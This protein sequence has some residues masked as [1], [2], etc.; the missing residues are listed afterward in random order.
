[1][2]KNIFSF[3]TTDGLTLPWLIYSPKSWSKEIALLLHGN[4]SSS[5]FYSMEK[6][7]LMAEAITTQWIAFAPFNNRGA[8]YH[9][10]FK[11]LNAQWE[12]WKKHGGMAFELLEECIIDI[13]C[14]VDYL[15]TLGYEKFHLIGNSTWANK[16]CTYH[17]HK[18][19]T[20]FSSYLLVAA[21]DDTGLYYEFIGKDNFHRLLN[22]SKEKIDQWLWEEFVPREEVFGMLLSY[23]SLYDTI[24]PDWDYNAFPYNEY[25]NSLNLS[26]KPLFRYFNTI[27]IPTSVI[28]WEVDEFCSWPAKQSIDALKKHQNPLIEIQYSI[29]PGADH[30][31]TGYYSEL[32]EA[33]GKH[34]WSL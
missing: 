17:R 15:K 29:V 26:T 33:V 21:G 25:F 23:Q 10:K 27:D 7:N 4:W 24:N 6:Y 14:L 9:K 1:M 8:H 18:D 19:S 2:N 13:D 32:A 5:V 28:Y 16:I 31:F 20:P 30:G 34:F 12:K 11:G 22:V 3:N